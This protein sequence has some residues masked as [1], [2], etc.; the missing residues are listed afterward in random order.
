MPRK[1]RLPAQIK[2]RLPEAL[3]RELERE[4]AKNSRTLN[5]E[6]VYR[7][8]QPFVQADRKAIAAAA[9]EAAGVAAG[10]AV[11]EA[12]AELGLLPKPEGGDK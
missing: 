9:A 7:L 8:T 12:V 1:K 4:A 2:I 11:A 5:G 3:R 6:I 10:K